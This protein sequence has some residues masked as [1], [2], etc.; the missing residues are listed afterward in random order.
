MEHV[1]EVEE[2]VRIRH[3]I[4]VDVSSD[5]DIQNALDCV[6]EYCGSLD[7]FVYGIAQHLNVVCVNE[8]VY[9]ETE[10]VEY[11]DDYDSYD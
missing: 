9:A 2:V 1:I 5:I 3:Q 7:R 4:I 6:D 11:F 8:E 10:S